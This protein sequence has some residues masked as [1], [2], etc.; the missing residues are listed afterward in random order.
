[1][2]GDDLS[3]SL[4]QQMHFE[5]TLS[6]SLVGESTEKVLFKVINLLGFFLAS[7]VF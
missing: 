3:S 4:L 5:A 1:M 7:H 2:A 6:H